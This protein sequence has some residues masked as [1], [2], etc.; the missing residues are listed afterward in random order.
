MKSLENKSKNQLLKDPLR[1]QRQ[2]ELLIALIRQQDDLELL[3]TDGPRFDSKGHNATDPALWL[4]RNRRILAKYQAL[5]TSSITLD[6]L[7]DS[8]GIQ[9][10]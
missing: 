1:R 8:E 5:V 10:D 7:L 3:D 2:H 9:S 4:E 6:A